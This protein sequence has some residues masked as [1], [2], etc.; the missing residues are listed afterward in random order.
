MSRTHTQSTLAGRALIALRAGQMSTDELV[1]R[2]GGGI[3]TVLTR[4]RGE[5]L[6]DRLDGLGHD[7]LWRLTD[8]GRTACPRRRDPVEPPRLPYPP[9][10]AKQGVHAA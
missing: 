5:G 8:A 4:L 1:A 10:N 6:V 7:T 3:T 9:R 2:F